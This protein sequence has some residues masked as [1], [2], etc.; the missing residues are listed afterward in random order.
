MVWRDQPMVKKAF[1]G[2]FWESMGKIG[3][4]YATDYSVSP[5]GSVST[6]SPQKIPLAAASGGSSGAARMYAQY[7]IKR[8][9]MYHLIIQLPSDTIIDITFLK[10]FWLDGGTDTTAPNEVEPQHNTV[11]T[12]DVANNESETPEEKAAKQFFYKE[13]AF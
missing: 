1:W 5:L 8:A 13:H 2:S 10:G 6:L 7:T 3:Q 12:I 4:Q 9:E 11:N